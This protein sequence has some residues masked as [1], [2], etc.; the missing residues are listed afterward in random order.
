MRR[1]ALVKKFAM[2]NNLALTDMYAAEKAMM[3]EVESK[4]AETML[5]DIEKF[6]L[7]PKDPDVIHSVGICRAERRRAQESVDSPPLTNTEERGNRR[8]L[9]NLHQRERTRENI[10]RR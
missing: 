10:R 4:E 7:D 8:F 5:K 6:G 9:L 3:A 2:D 1:A